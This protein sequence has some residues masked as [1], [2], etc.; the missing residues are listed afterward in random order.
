MRQSSVRTWA[1]SR[2]SKS[3]PFR[4][5]SRIRPL[6]D[7]DPGVLPWRARIDEDR[8]GAVEAAPVG[9]GV[10]DE[11]GAVVEAHVG[12]G[13]A[14]SGELSRQRDHV[15]GVDGAVDLDGESTR[16]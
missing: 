10:G 2:E 14:L 15:V 12:R 9:D 7:L 8:L 16:G 6:K 3:W 4:C 1:S 5:S 11:L 13:A